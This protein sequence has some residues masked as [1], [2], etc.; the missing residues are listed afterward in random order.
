MKY[1][2]LLA[3]TIIDHS[4]LKLYLAVIIA[5]NDHPD[6]VSGVCCQSRDLTC[7]CESA[8]ADKPRHASAGQWVYVSGNS[9]LSAVCTAINRTAAIVHGA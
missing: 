7:F 3:A 4:A 8:A 5:V 2:A 6:E 9:H 1:R